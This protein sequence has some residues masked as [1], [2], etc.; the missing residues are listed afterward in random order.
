MQVSVEKPESGLEYK[1]SVSVPS[2]ELDSKIEKRL[3][4]MKR[5]VRM[6]GFRPGK[7]PLSV[8]KKRYGQQVRQEMLGE[9]VQR[10]FYDAVTQE[11]LNVAG[12]PTFEKLEE[13][14]GNIEFTAVFEIFPEVDLPELSKIKVAAPPLGTKPSLA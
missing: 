4:E 10:A 8:V 5:N 11:D 7:V 9:E 12:F 3:N 6:D 14:D 13:N 1:M 2:G